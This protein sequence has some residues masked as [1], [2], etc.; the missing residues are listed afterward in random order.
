MDESVPDGCVTGYEDLIDA[1]TLPDPNDRHVLAAAIHC[2][3]NVIV[4]F[5]DADFPA[6]TIQVAGRRRSVDRGPPRP[7]VGQP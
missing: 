7:G 6:E 4:T 2:G 3:A 1:L 5:N